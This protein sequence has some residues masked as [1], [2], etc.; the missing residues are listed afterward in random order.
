M[1]L[2]EKTIVSQFAGKV[3]MKNIPLSLCAVITALSVVVSGQPVEA[4]LITGS[5][6]ISFSSRTLSA[7]TDGSTDLVLANQ[8][9]LSN[10]QDN[11]G[12]G[13][14]NTGNFQDVADGGTGP[15]VAFRTSL[16][17]ATSS[18]PLVLQFHTGASIFTFGNST[19][20]T[21]TAT[22]QKDVI[23]T[24]T[25]TETFTGTFTP[26]NP[27]Y[28]DSTLTGNTAELLFIFNQT[29]GAGSAVSGSATLETPAPVPEPA[30]ISMLSTALGL[31][32]VVA[33]VRRF[34]RR[35]AHATVSAAASGVVVGPSIE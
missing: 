32:G 23:G 18:S 29:G 21:F 14:A 24:H 1:Q 2:N 28:G 27:F 10:V 16:S 11:G 17:N 31:F 9:R 35:K 7:V 22:S 25:R 19:W 6:A 15:G 20:G 12:G 3:L 5:E 30:T 4:G 8:I 26:A 34:R 13:G 33:G